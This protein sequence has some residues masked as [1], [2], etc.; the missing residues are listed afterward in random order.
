VWSDVNAAFADKLASMSVAAILA[1][2]NGAA[3]A[4]DYC[5]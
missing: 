4:L 5:I 2:G 3:E 1:H